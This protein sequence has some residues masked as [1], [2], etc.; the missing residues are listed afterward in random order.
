M[1]HV[2]T[3]F[4]QLPSEKIIG[5]TFSSRRTVSEYD[6]LSFA[7]ITGDLA[8]NHT[9]EVHMR[10][11]NFKGRIAHGV[12]VL[13]YTSALSTQVA[14][15]ILEPVVSLGY[16]R[17]RFTNPVYLGT[18]V[19]CSYWVESIDRNALRTSAH[20]TVRDVCSGET[21]LVA[22]HI[23]KVTPSETRVVP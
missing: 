18:T 7:G 8:A 22:N 12:L 19:E 16:D 2:P 1:T 6:V 14:D 17:V 9:D 13:G 15:L 21:L 10:Q 20:A 4:A 3:P 23:M 5:R 11:S